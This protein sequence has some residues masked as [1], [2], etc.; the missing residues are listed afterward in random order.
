MCSVDMAVR[1]SLTTVNFTGVYGAGRDAESFLQ[2]FDELGT[3]F[4]FGLVKQ[5]HRVCKSVDFL[6]QFA[7]M[8]TLFARDFN[9]TTNVAEITEGLVKERNGG[10]EIIF[11]GS[12]VQD[13]FSSV[14]LRLAVIFEFGGHRGSLLRYV[15]VTESVQDT[16]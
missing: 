5:G 3:P 2:V 16:G 8:D 13:P 6:P 1:Y 4:L 11:F 7:F 15:Q 14:L 12:V 9:S 10:Y